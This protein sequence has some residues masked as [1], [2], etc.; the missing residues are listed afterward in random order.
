M[1]PTQSTHER[2]LPV[3]D[4]E[5]C[6]EVSDCGRVRSVSRTIQR[7][8]GATMRIRSRIR[9]TYQSKSG[10]LSTSLSKAGVIRTH[11]V[12]YL[13]I[14]AFEGERPDGMDIRHLNGDP[15]DNRLSNLAYGTRSE[16]CQDSIE[17]G[18]A[19]EQAKTCCPYGHSYEGANLRIANWKKNGRRYQVRHCRACERAAARKSVR[20]GDRDRREVADEIYASLIVATKDYAPSPDDAGAHITITERTEP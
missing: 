7:S 14:L 2:W 20:E 12:H 11:H 6:Y 10:H 17:H 1:N 5:G 19:W 13:V 8:T 4:Y 9:K 16:N 15:T 18:T 3:P